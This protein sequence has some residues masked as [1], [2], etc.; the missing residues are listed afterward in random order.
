MQLAG[1]GTVPYLAPKSV[2]RN[3]FLFK[4]DVWAVDVM[5]YRMLLGELLS[6]DDNICEPQ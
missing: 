2:R 5:T 3:V 6:D 4:T 1:G